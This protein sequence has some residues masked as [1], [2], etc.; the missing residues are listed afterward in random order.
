[1]FK[2]V[3]RN[4]KANSFCAAVVQ[5]HFSKHTT[6]MYGDGDGGFIGVPPVSSGGPRAKDENINKKN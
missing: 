1:M 6:S 5:Q 2:Y 4:L 3:Q